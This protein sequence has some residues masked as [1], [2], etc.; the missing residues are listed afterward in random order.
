MINEC[1]ILIYADDTV[2][3]YSDKSAKAVEDVINYEADLVGKWF[4]DNNLIMNL[5]KGITE[6]VMYGKSQKLTR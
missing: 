1:R 3:F 6:F 4:A 5:Q 2:I